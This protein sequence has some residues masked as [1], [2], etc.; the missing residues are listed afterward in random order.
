MI[1]IIDN[2][3]SFVYNLYQLV[4]PLVDEVRVVRN[5]RI[6]LS[7]IQA[8]KPQGIILSPG[9]GR[10]EDA[11]ICVDLI[12][13]FSGKIP[14]FG[15]CLGHQAMAIAFGGEVVSAGEI[16]HGKPE[17]IF[18]GGKNL[19]QDMPLPFMAGRYHSLMVAREHLPDEFAIDA[20]TANGLIM[21]MRHKEHLTF[22]VQ[23]HPESVLTP[24]GNKLLAAFCK[25]T[26]RS[27]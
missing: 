3:D 17:A 19:Y 23:F 21:G 9:P 2:Y 10:P 14:L 24:E 6:T 13:E 15:V 20:Q 4:A 8:L 12:R 22:G 16:I 1:L 7:E 18:H 5:D 27:D 25:L 26:C 11:G